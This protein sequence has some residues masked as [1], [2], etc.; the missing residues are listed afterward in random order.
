MM[1]SWKIGHGSI[2][3]L[4]LMF[5]GEATSVFFNP[6]LASREWLR[7]TG[8]Q[9]KVRPAP[10][11]AHSPA[12]GCTCAVCGLM[13]GQSIGPGLSPISLCTIPPAH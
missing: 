7:V 12:E 11:P 1:W 4:M 10:C 8:K 13:Q 3:S 6:W 9:S 2:S 5:L